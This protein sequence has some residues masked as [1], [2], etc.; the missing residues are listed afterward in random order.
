M[1]RTRKT[2]VAGA[3]H[4]QQQQTLLEQNMR[5]PDFSF[6]QDVAYHWFYRAL[7]SDSSSSDQWKPFTMVDSCAIEDAFGANP[8][9]GDL[10]PT[11]GGRYDVNIPERTKTAVFWQEEALPIRRCSWFF[12]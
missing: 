3:A 10:I 5:D 4:N 7:K 6:L 11:D 1:L 8:S 2:S 9:A 12:R